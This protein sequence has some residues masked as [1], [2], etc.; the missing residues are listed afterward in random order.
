MRIRNVSLDD[1]VV[2]AIGFTCITMLKRDHI[3]DPQIH[4]IENALQQYVFRAIFRY[5]THSFQ[6]AS[7]SYFGKVLSKFV[8]HNKNLGKD[9]LPFA[10]GYPCIAFKT[11]LRHAYKP[12]SQ[13]HMIEK[14][15]QKYI[16]RGHIS[17]WAHHFSLSPKRVLC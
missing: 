10:R 15:K 6:Q 17:M 14:N 7:E 2:F 3:T 4:R 12:I 8:R 13:V 16:L 1:F 11:V 5:G 9:F